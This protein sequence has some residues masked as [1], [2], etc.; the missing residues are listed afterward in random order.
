MNYSSADDG[1]IYQTNPVYSKPSQFKPK[2]WTDTTL[3]YIREANQ[4]A[5]CILRNRHLMKRPYS[6]VVH[7][8]LNEE[9]PPKTIKEM[10]PKVCRKLKDRG[11]VA[12]WVR[13]P[14]SLNK[15]HYHILIKNLISKSDLMKAIEESMPSREVVKWRKRVEPIRTEWWLYHYIVKAKVS[16]ENKKGIMVKDL[17]GPKRLLFLAKLKFKKVGTIGSFWE[18]GKN[19]KKIWDDIKAIEK[20]IAEGLEKPNMKRLSEYVY[21]FLG[22]CVPLKK[23]ERFYGYSSNSQ[24]LQNWIDS[25]LTDQWAEEDATLDGY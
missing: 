4:W 22:G 20:Q 23:I 19:K 7:L 25:L 16:G 17:Y 24:G 21:D 10:W 6:W 5:K 9:I 12:L 2:G 14:N 18:Q 11:I 8:N 13:E 3:G 15:C 1:K